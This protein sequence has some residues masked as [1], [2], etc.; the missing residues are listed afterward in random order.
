MGDINFAVVFPGQG[1]QS[2]G[3]L[4]DIIDAYPIVLDTL[5]QAS[6]VL[7]YDVIDIMLHDPD[8]KLAQTEFT[9]PIMLAS[10]IALWRLFQ[11][12]SSSQPSV[13]AGHS[14]GEFAALVA[15]ESI[16]Y[17]DALLL[18]SKRAFYMQSAVMHGEG[19][20][21]AIIGLDNEAISSCCEDVASVGVVSPANYNSI[22]QTV[23]AG[24]VKA[25]EAVL[26]RVK[27]QGA[28]LAK[29]IPVSV[30]SHCALMQSAMEKFTVDI[31]HTNIKPPKI[32]LL[33]N[34]DVLSHQNVD[35]IKNM[36]LKQLILPV[37]WVE[38][39]EKLGEMGVKAIIECGPGNVLYGLN[40]R[41]NKQLTQYVLSKDFDRIDSFF[42]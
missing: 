30:P 36:L 33:H 15:A 34:A 8:G 12:R 2:L 42:N 1:S 32:P 13:L 28:K 18:V 26:L 10:D 31:N 21:A 4:S 41:I 23:V 6:D 38:T 27:E 20:M 25:V 40:K 11:S 9:Q 39:I 24:E 35:M 19:A 17:E 7:G 22:G 3:M 29:I 37:R 14:L 16:M 5:K